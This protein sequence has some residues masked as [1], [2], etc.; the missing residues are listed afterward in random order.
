M[1]K[2]GGRIKNGDKMERF[3]YYF[4]SL[5]RW[6]KT[7]GKKEI[8]HWFTSKFLPPNSEEKERA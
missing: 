6:R 7:G 1:Q 2:M 8:M 3:Y 5:G 4:F